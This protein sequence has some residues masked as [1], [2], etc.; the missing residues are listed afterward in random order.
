MLFFVTGASGAGKSA[1]VNPLIQLLPHIKVHDFFEV[2]A[3]SEYYTDWETR[4]IEKRQRAT[5]YWLQQALVNQKAGINMVVCGGVVLGE[6]LACPSATQVDQ[7]EV[8]LLD[9]YDV[10]R[11]D[12]VRGRGHGTGEA[13]QETLCW[14]GWL[15][16]HAVDPQWRQDVIKEMAAPEMQWSRWDTWQ[17]GDPRWQTWRLDTTNLSIEEVASQVAAWVANETTNN[18]KP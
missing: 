14:A 13:S 7:I 12:R 10:L 5:E 17:R 9:C 3:I 18:V 2:C 4:A 11:I 15:R 1:C 16:L 8:C 6:I